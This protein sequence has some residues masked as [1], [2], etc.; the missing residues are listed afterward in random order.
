MYLVLE[1]CNVMQINEHLKPLMLNVY[2]HTHTH[3]HTMHN[4]ILKALSVINI[5]GLMQP[6]LNSVLLQITMDI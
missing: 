2:T 3:T 1:F 4:V 6:H 5:S